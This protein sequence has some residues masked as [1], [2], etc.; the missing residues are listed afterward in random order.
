MVVGLIFFCFCFVFL[1]RF[2]FVVNV[3]FFVFE[4]VLD[5]GV[6]KLVD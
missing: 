3:W 5:I 1:F 6:V 2:F 4:D